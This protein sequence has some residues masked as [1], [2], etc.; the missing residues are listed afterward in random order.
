MQIDLS[1]INDIILF[2]GSLY[3]ITPFV[4]AFINSITKK[5]F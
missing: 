5:I 2:G 1:L 3:L 4:I